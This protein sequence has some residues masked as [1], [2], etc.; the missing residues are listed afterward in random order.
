[1]P[2]RNERAPDR[3][4]AP[5]KAAH[6]LMRAGRGDEACQFLDQAKQ[7]AQAEG[8]TDD[9]ALY[10]SV[11]GS[12]LAAMGR[13]EEALEAYQGAEQLSKSDPHYR[14]TTA[15]HL[16]WGMSLPSEALELVDAIPDSE[17]ENAGILL[18]AHAIRGLCHLAQQQEAQAIRELEAVVSLIARRMPP[19]LSCDLTLVEELARQ[20]IAP[21]LCRDYLEQVEAQARKEEET[22]VV[23]RVAEL[24]SLLPT[25]QPPA[26]Q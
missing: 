20:R 19:S 11:R 17:I 10:S 4:E 3:F 15:R 21:D 16:L 14:L 24:K 12:Y 7:K 2:P 22:R 9:A 13:N 6:E 25:R 1:M 5:L 8:S 18:E 23:S 26:G